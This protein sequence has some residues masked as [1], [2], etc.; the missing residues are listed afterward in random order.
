[1]Y[2][3]VSEAEVKTLAKI[4]KRKGLPRTLAALD[5]GVSVPTLNKM[6][7]P[8]CVGDWPTNSAIAH[9]LR[10]YISM[11]GG[12]IE[13]ASKAVDELIRRAESIKNRKRT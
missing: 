11:N 9:K 8:R 13:M 10:H 6:L 5:I 12:R 3:T 2:V 4:V 1:M 7:G